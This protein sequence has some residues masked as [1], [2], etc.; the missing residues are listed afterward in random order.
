MMNRYL[1]GCLVVV[2][3]LASLVHA[4]PAA[5]VVVA[6]PERKRIRQTV[7]QPATVEAYESTPIH[8]K[9]SGY[10]AHVHVDMGQHVTANEELAV[11]AMPELDAEFQQREAAVSE[12]TSRFKQARAAAEVARAHVPVVEAELS[13]RESA[14]RRTTAVVEL[15]KSELD[16]LTQLAQRQAIDEKTVDEAR[17]SHNAALADRDEA[18]GRVVAARAAVDES[19]AAVLQADADSGTAEAQAKVAEAARQHTAALL[20]Y[21]SIRAPFTGVISKRLV[22]TGHLVQPSG[23]GGPLFEV[24]RTDRLRVCID[25]PESHAPL[26]DVGDAVAVRFPSAPIAPQSGKLDRVSW[27]LDRT[28]RTLRAEFDVTNTAV[29]LRPGMYAY[30]TITLAEKN[31]ALVVPA[32]AVVDGKDGAYCSCVVAGKVERTPVQLGLRT[33]SEVEIL[34]GLGDASLVIRNGGANLGDGQAVEIAK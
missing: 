27:T 18:A 34:S 29:G 30:A 17:E 31:L 23:Q 21:K 12:A 32:S 25:V 33:A 22:H 2:M 20:A 11:L 8:A 4:Q 5:T 19:R 6:R 10:I 26:V 14:V 24:V 13:A 16:R 28:A 15:R 3:S 1:A 7:E 9:L